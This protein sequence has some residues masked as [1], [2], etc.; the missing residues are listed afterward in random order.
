MSL[1]TAAFFALVGMI[2]LT[3]VLAFGF[4]LSA[5][6]VHSTFWPRYRISTRPSCHSQTATLPLAG[7][8]WFPSRCTC[9][10][11]FPYRTTRQWPENI[12]LVFRRQRD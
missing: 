12:N 3:V 10:N 9:R 8:W 7:A 2:L 1:K 5:I 4:I 6:S 11:R